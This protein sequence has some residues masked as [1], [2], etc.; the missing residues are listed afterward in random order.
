MV[1]GRKFDSI[2]VMGTFVTFI[3]LSTT[4]LLTKTT[5]FKN[6]LGVIR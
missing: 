5:P 3:P 2:Y 6:H 1:F 4:N